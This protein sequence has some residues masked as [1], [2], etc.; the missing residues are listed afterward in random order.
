MKAP[1]SSPENS[2]EAITNKNDKEIHEE[3]YI[4]PKVRRK[5]IDNLRV[6]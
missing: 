5:I 6:I 1:R 2:S 4:S 3:R